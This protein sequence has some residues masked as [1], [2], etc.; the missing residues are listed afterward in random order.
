LALDPGGRPLDPLLVV[1]A[2]E[3]A[4][5]APDVRRRAAAALAAT[6]RCTV[7]VAGRSGRIPGELADSVDLGL[8]ADPDGAD[9]QTVAVVDV[10]AALGALEDRFAAAPLA[11]LSYVWLLRQS[12]GLPVPAALT[13]ESA[14]YSTL[15]A[16]PE[17]GGWLAE[18]GPARPPDDRS[19]RVQ[20]RRSGDL[21]H[22]RLSRPAR[23][24]AVDAAMRDAL[25]AALAP[26]QW[27]RALRV[28]LSGEG[29][30][31]SAGGDLDEFGSAVDPASAHVLRLG[32]S[33]AEVL[34]QLRDRVTV[35]VHGTCLGAGFELPCFAGRV[36]A[37]P[38]TRLGLPELSMGLIPGAGG[39]ASVVRRAGRWRAAWLGLTGTRIDAR[40][41]LDWGLV[42]EIA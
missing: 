10:P 17:F 6:R 25:L 27:D 2:E 34:S 12:A 7:A 42:D 18:R 11:A 32:A 20:T 31:F 33:V 13:A 22:V 36:V 15:L 14:A 35:R 28:E 9:T 29:P 4:L 8:T 39:T 30:T 1:R 19:G 3:F 41:A 40:T 21:L 16:G 23:R 38:D 26:A 24:N 5:L 37:A